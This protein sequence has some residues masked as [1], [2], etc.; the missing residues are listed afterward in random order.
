[1]ELIAGLPGDTFEGLRRSLDDA[2]LRWPDHVSVYRLLGLKGTPLAREANRLGLQFSPKPP[3]ELVK[4]ASFHPEALEQVNVLTFAHM[5]LFNLGVGRYALRYLVEVFG[6]QPSEV[7]D[8]FLKVMFAEG[9]YSLEQARHLGRHH[10]YGN[11]FDQSMPV[12]LELPR[13]HRATRYF[14]ERVAID[15]LGEKERRL[16][17]DLVDFG[18]SLAILDGVKAKVPPTNWGADWLPQIAPWCRRQTYSCSV[19]EELVRQGHDLG[20]LAPHE[21]AA[22]VFFVHPELGPA[23]LAADAPTTEFLNAVEHG[24]CGAHNTATE[25]LRGLAIL[26]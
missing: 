10:A 15:L 24:M 9:I 1:M 26:V 13:V 7:Y 6:T 22:V 18:H 21:V 5:V 14:F 19:I 25:T 11:R 17:L 23:A 8:E 2:V 3:Y 12:G 16:A 4:S 20:E